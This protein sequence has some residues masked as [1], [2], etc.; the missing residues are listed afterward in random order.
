M[1]S[2]HPNVI[3]LIAADGASHT[4]NARE[5]RHWAPSLAGAHG[6]IRELSDA[7]IESTK[8]LE[9]FAALVSYGTLDSHHGTGLFALL[10]FLDKWAPSLVDTFARQVVHAVWRRDHALHPQLAVALLATAGKREMVREVLF[11]APLELGLGEEDGEK[12]E[13]WGTVPEAYRAAIEEA[14]AEVQALEGDAR[15]EALPTAF[16]KYFKA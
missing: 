4:F 13:V 10:A 15:L 16:D 7:S 14:S 1:S 8:V 11:L 9:A 12:R 3:I 5:L 2:P 6:Y